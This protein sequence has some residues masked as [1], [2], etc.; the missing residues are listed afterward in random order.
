[1]RMPTWEHVDEEVD[2]EIRALRVHDASAQRSARIRARCVAVLEARR[3]KEEPREHAA[4]GWRSWLEPAFAFGLSILYL[5]DA[6]KGAL[7]LYR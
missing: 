2:D 5:A 6:V 7:A 4:G 1:M 3:P